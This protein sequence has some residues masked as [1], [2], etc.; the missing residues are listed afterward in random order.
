MMD[1]TVASFI[2]VAIIIVGTACTQAVVGFGFALLSVPI[3]IQVIGF[4][5]AVIL[6]TFI[7]T[8]NNLYQNRELRRD[9]DVVQVK[10]FLYASFLGAPI[11]AISFRFADQQV[12][13]IFLGIGVLLG[14]VLLVRG[15]D[16]S[17]AHV[18]L[19][20]AMGVLSGFLLTTTS[21]NGP[22]LVFALQARKSSPQVFRATLNK[23]FLISGVYAI[24]LFVVFGEVAISDLLL[25][26]FMLP[27]MIIGVSI[28][29]VIRNRI[30]PDRFRLAVLVL[31]TIAGFSSVYSGVFQ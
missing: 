2:A 25:A 8:A 16:L 29:R 20:W 3:L 14:V 12:L 24:F 10:R 31:L 13:K 17:E 19:D 6:S 30:D 5:Q 1:I 21:T 28:G 7:G 9:Q 22:P 27:S 26:A 4:H 18:S 23:I 15:K 11:G